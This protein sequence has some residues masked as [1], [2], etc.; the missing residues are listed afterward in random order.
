MVFSKGTRVCG[1]AVTVT[2]AQPGWHQLPSQ[3]VL[4]SQGLY[5]CKILSAWIQLSNLNLYD[6]KRAAQ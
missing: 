2:Q 5:V 4:R 6:P 1:G 3:L